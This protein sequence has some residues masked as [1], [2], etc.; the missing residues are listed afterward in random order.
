MFS[1]R[2]LQK[3]NMHYYEKGLV[4]KMD[5]LQGKHFSITDP[6]G[7]NTVIYQINKTEKEY[8][9][10]Y[11]KYTVSRL[12]Y[13]AEI[14]GDATRKTYFVDDPSPDRKPTCNFFICKRKG[15]N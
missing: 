14:R 9:K 3:K 13:T 8:L 10:D 1:G 12:D 5:I 15:C 2:I 7:I 6:Q 4:F 11:P